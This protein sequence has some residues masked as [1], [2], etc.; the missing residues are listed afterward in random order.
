V[1]ISSYLFLFLL[2][3]PARFAVFSARKG[4]KEEKKRKRKGTYCRRRLT[5]HR[6]WARSVWSRTSH[7]LTKASTAPAANHFLLFLL[8][9]FLI[10]AV[11]I[12]E[13]K[14]IMPGLKR[15]EEIGNGGSQILAPNH[16]FV[17]KDR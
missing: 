8:F 3:W 5:G 4:Q 16:D 13:I 2:F 9:L 7:C 6:Q 10:L 17:I 12:Q 11:Q 1:E 14:E 15:K